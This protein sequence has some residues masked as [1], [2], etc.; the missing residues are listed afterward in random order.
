MEIM[1]YSNDNEVAYFLDTNEKIEKIDKE[2]IHIYIKGLLDAAN[3]NNNKI[4]KIY[5]IN[6]LLKYIMTLE[7][8]ISKNLSFCNV[9]DK[10]INELYDQLYIIQSSEITFAKEVTSTFKKA[11]E[12]INMIKNVKNSN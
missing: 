5:Y 3:N 4:I 2:N 1:A 12:F 8:F 9:I 7:A 6:W 11:R 10:K